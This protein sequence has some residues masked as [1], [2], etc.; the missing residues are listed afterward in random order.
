MKYPLHILIVEDE[1]LIGL[2]LKAILLS[3]GHTVLKVVSTG[4]DAIEKAKELKPDLIFMDINLK[5]FVTGIEAAESIH[6]DNVIPIIYITAMS[7]ISPNLLFPY[8]LITKPYFKEDIISAI[9]ETM[10]S[11]SVNK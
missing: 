11:Y 2:E 5:D 7:T 3:L 4:K 6:L 9:E 1:T 10:R 8:I